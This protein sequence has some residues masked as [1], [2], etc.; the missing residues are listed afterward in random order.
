[1][2]YKN[3]YCCVA[4]SAMTNTVML[5]LECINNKNGFMIYIMEY[6]DVFH[7]IE[8]EALFMVTR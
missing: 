1:M 8:T 5:Q 2:V 6:L 4:F 3:R 7:G